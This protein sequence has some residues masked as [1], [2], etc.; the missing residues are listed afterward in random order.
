ML[1]KTFI[2]E[3]LS[4]NSYIVCDV[5]KRPSSTPAVIQTDISRLRAKRVSR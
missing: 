2:S 4:H 1:L 3:G 5:G